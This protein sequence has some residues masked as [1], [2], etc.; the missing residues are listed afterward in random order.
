MTEVIASLLCYY[1]KGTPS[2]LWYVGLQ[3]EKERGGRESWMILYLT[4]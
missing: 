3:I 2:H 1:A 4:G